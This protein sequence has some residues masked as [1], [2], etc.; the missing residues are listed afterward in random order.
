MSNASGILGAG[1]GGEAR[2]SRLA[3]THNYNDSVALS[4]RTQVSFKQQDY[5]AA[6]RY[7]RRPHES[8]IPVSALS[9]CDKLLLMYRYEHNR[10]KQQ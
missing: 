5:G 1:K 7:F 8:G 3:F 6:R 4:S 9:T 2:M 10:R